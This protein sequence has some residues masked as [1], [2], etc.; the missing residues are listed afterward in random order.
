MLAKTGRKLNTFAKTNS[1]TETQWGVGHPRE[2]N[3]TRNKTASSK[4]ISGYKHCITATELTN[5]RINLLW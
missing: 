4:L 2:Q 1:L 5:E 3:Y